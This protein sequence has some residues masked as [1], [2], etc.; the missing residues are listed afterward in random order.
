M[1]A[2]KPTEIKPLQHEWLARYTAKEIDLT[3]VFR[4]PYYYWDREGLSFFAQYGT[5][6][7]KREA[8][9]DGDIDWRKKAQQIGIDTTSLDL[10]DP[11]SP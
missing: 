10:R 7:I 6:K 1:F 3:S 2:V 9:W 4:Q 5:A 11:R 8:I